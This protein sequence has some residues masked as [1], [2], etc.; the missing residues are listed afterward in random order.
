MLSLL[1]SSVTWKKN[2]FSWSA[3]GVRLRF[4]LR[5]HHLIHSRTCARHWERCHLLSIPVALLCVSWYHTFLFPDTVGSSF[6]IRPSLCRHPEDKILGCSWIWNK[7]DSIILKCP[8]PF[9]IMILHAMCCECKSQLLSPKI[10]VILRD[11][12]ASW[13][14]EFTLL[15]PSPVP[16]HSRGRRW[17]TWGACPPSGHA[18]QGQSRFHFWSLIGPRLGFLWANSQGFLAYWIPWSSS[19]L[20]SSQE[21][22]MLNSAANFP[23]Y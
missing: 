1:S 20:R 7:C 3:V 6:P 9:S 4:G 8:Y 11:S 22:E 17:L 16:V 19:G 23:C 21:Q 10:K 15:L 14:L 13:R 2:R 5:L 12:P 18:C